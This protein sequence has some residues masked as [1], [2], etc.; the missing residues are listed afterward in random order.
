MGRLS[1]QKLDRDFQVESDTKLR[2]WIYP[3][4]DVDE[5][6]IRLSLWAGTRFAGR[7]GIRTA[8]TDELLA[9]A[10]LTS[11]QALDLVRRLTN[12]IGRGPTT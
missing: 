9:C 11:E 4:V 12:A 8:E 2:K 3:A 5:G 10:E 7:V 6:V 1:E